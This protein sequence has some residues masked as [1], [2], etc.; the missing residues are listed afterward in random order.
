MCVNARVSVFVYVYE[1]VC[2]YECV[3]MRMCEYIFGG[4]LGVWRLVKGEVGEFYLVF[5]C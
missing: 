3:Y 5:I 2:V 4:V 1:C